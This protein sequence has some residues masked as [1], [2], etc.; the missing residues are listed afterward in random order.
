MQFFFI[1]SFF[2][3]MKPKFIHVE[4]S[5]YVIPTWKWFQFIIFFYL[6]IISLWV[7][8]YTFSIT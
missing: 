6:T 3:F 4:I 1:S 5:F 2:W 7:T 8:I